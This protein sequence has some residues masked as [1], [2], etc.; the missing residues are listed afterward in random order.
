MLWLYVSLMECIAELLRGHAPV[1]FANFYN[2]FIVWTRVKA[3]W[4]LNKVLVLVMVIIVLNWLLV[5]VRVKRYHRLNIHYTPTIR[6]RGVIH[7]NNFLALDQNFTYSLTLNS[8]WFDGRDTICFLF[9]NLSILE[10]ILQAIP[11][12]VDIL[13]LKWR[14]ELESYATANRLSTEL[15]KAGNSWS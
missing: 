8:A 5:G 4:L 3:L 7:V 11:S 14:M 12:L 6:Q 1:R 15:G 9:R 10:H 13:Q 2:D